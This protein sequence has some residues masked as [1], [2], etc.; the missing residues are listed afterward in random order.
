ML[1]DPE[2]FDLAELCDAADV[3]PRTVRY[4]VQ[5]GLLP[6]PGTRGPGTRYDRGHLDR[7]LLIKRLQREHLPL[8]E[9]R[10]RLASLDDAAV[11]ALLHQPSERPADSSALAYLRDVLA[12]H[13][14]SAEAPI[15]R[16]ILPPSA[17]SPRRDARRPPPAMSE[18]ADMVAEL[19]EG[20]FAPQ[21]GRVSAPVAVHEGQDRLYN[22]R[23]TWERI[24]LAPDIELHVRRPMSR[25]ENKLVDRLI[26][27]AR[28]LFSKTEE[29]R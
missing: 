20:A 24:A 18:D 8:A 12:G 28:T 21:H 19:G 16:G 9:I 17:P 4:Y 22:D 2:T 14:P 27:Y 1:P 25:P 3:T 7:V 26:E 11:A 10:R 29:R 15:A 6:S 13:T 23:S 5:Q